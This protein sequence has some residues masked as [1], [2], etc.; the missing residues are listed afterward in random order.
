M[1]DNISD[2]DHVHVHPYNVEKNEQNKVEQKIETS[3]HAKDNQIVNQII[4]KRDKQIQQL[5]K[6]IE[7]GTYKVQPMKVAEKMLSYFNKK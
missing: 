2:E 6:Q 3:P 1:K 5:K 4:A 7:E